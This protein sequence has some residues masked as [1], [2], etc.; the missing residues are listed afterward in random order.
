[1]NPGQTTKQHRTYDA[2][3][4]YEVPREWDSSTSR[5]GFSLTE[6]LIVMIVIAVMTGIASGQYTSYRDRTVPDRS[7]RVVGSYVSLTRSYAIQRRSPVT[8]AVDEVAM[9]IMIRGESD[10]IRTI[11]FGPDSDFQLSTLST[12][13]AGDSLTFN[14][15]GLCTVCGTSG[16]A[17]TVASRGTTYLV[18][19]NALGRWKKTL[20]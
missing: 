12:N 8:L 2:V 10:T 1:M 4:I 13:F 6:L 11:Q 18:T 9:S 19:F 5:A 17:I 15:R 20:Q 16:K 3:G 14:A 7:A